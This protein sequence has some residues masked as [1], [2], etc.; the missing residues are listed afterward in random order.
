MLEYLQ[1]KRTPSKRL[2]FTER[3][4]RES[5][6]L[7]R[8]MGGSLELEGGR[9]TRSSTRGTPAQSRVET[10]PTNITPPSAKK[11]R[12]SSDN[13]E[14]ATTPSSHKAQGRRRGRKLNVNSGLSSSDDSTAIDHNTDANDLPLNNVKENDKDEKESRLVVQNNEQNDEK[15]ADVV[16]DSLEEKQNNAEKQ[17]QGQG[18]VIKSEGEQAQAIPTSD[19]VSVH[20]LTSNMQLFI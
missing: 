18:V 2:T 10:T 15:D 3:A 11:P 13:K 20:Y 17:E 9:R 7:V 16:M 1:K 14:G 4:Q 8:T 6:E 5:E 12:K 19:N